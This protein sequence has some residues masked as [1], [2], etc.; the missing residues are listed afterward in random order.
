VILFVFAIMDDRNARFESPATAGR[1]STLAI[2]DDRNDPSKS[3]ATDG[4]FL[5]LAIMD[6]SQLH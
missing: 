2:T 4:R 5:I 3:P 1:F 6:R